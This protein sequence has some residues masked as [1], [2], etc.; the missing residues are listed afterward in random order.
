MVLQLRAGCVTSVPTQGE[1]GTCSCVH[2]L[3]ILLQDKESMQS[4][5]RHGCFSDIYP[6]QGAYANS[7]EAWTLQKHLPRS[8]WRTGINTA[9][10]ANTHCVASRYVKPLQPSHSLL[11][12]AASSIVLAVLLLWAQSTLCSRR[13]VRFCDRT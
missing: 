7:H 9:T 2:V 6:R 11:A 1:C 4:V 3:L 12:A 5:M 13:C 10:Y 8:G